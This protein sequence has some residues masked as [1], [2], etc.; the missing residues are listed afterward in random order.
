MLKPDAPPSCPLYP[1]VFPPAC[2]LYI[3]PKL[4]VDVGQVADAHAM[5]SL[6]SLFA[7]P[8]QQMAGT[9]MRRLIDVFI[10]PAGCFL[11]LSMS[12][13]AQV[14]DTVPWCLEIVQPDW[15]GCTQWAGRISYW[16]AARFPSVRDGLLFL[17]RHRSVEFAFQQQIGW[18][19]RLWRRRKS[20]PQSDASH[21]R[22]GWAYDV[23]FLLI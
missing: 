7:C 1:P 10:A 2:R 18:G 15:R 9:L 17:H 23:P 22:N 12:S 13:F 16:R 3:S 8:S 6:P 4:P 11:K 20:A 5:R 19:V 14:G 21:H